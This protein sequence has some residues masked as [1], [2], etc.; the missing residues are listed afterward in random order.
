VSGRAPTPT[1]DRGGARDG[2]PLLEIRGLEVRFP[3][4]RSLADR[5][6][7][8]PGVELIALDGVDLDVR[9]GA[10]VG[11]VGESGCGKS[12]LARALVGIERPRAGAMLLGG[13]ELDAMD[14]VSRARGIQMVF[15]DPRSSLNPR[16]KVG[17]ALAEILRVHG[18]VPREGVDDRVIELLATVGLEGRFAAAYPS[19]LSGGQRQRVAIARALALEPAVLVAD[20]PTSALDVSIQASVLNLLMDLRERLALTVLFISHDITVVR[21]L[22]ERVAVMYLGRIVEE[23]P[24]SDVL[25]VPR[26]PYTASLLEAVP[27]IGGR[28]HNRDPALHGEPPSPLRIPSGCRFHPRCPLARDVC[29]TDEPALLEQPSAGGRRA[30]CHFADQVSDRAAAGLNLTP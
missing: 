18:I 28:A 27:E 19:Q 21:H 3:V 11:L 23:G 1:A 8:R 17:A 2:S 29:R 20:E 25:R 7:R 24:T 12:T 15:Q 10:A 26:H 9:S 5:I 13:V 14:R 6:R 4:G 22:C 16:I 30:A